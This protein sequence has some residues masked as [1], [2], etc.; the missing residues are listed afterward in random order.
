MLPSRACYP[1]CRSSSAFPKM[2]R[3]CLVAPHTFH[4]LSVDLS[5]QAYGKGKLLEQRHA[6]FER[7]HVVADLTQ[8]L[9]TAFDPRAGLG[10]QQL[11]ERRLGTFN[12]AGENGF[13]PEK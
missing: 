12:L 1:A 9:G 2:P 5:N 10:S 6:M 11:S 13:A 4:Q 7:N 3:Y 8:I